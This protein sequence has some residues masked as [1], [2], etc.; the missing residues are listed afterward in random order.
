M[1][2][3]K[4]YRH[5]DKYSNLFS[6]ENDYSNELFLYFGIPLKEKLFSEKQKE[7]KFCSFNLKNKFCSLIIFFYSIVIICFFSLSV[8]LYI[9]IKYK[10]SSVKIKKN[11]ILIIRDFASLNKVSFIQTKGVQFLYDTFSLPEFY[12]DSIFHIEL[13]QKLLS[14]IIIPLISLGDLHKLIK[15]SYRLFGLE[16]TAKILYFYKLRLV[17]KS[18]FEFYAK[19]YLRNKKVINYI[20]ANKDDRYASLEKRLCEQY[21]K[22]SIGI[23]HGLEYSYKLPNGL[24]GNT[25]YCTSKK[26]QLFLTQ[27]YKNKNSFKY[28][29]NICRKMFEKKI[30][31]ISKLKKIVFFPETREIEK[32]LSIIKF[33]NY[34]NIPYFIK[35]SNSD[36]IR[37]YLPYITKS[38]LIDDFSEAIGNNYCLARKSTILLEAL[39]NNS[40]SYAILIDKRDKTIFENVFPSLW[41]D[42]INRI[43]NFEDLKTTILKLLKNN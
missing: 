1:N 7:N 27:L 41:D 12:K 11:S 17:H 26:A 33:L 29:P 15:D 43:Y 10:F 18:A 31:K 19:N 40:E 14:L 21:S 39:Y 4:L 16:I 35:L 20:T 6:K 30:T 32:N 8:S 13:K 36:N 37:S 22:N 23:P 25:F 28:D 9:F 34:L 38:M 3:D 42:K 2:Q 5:L 24:A